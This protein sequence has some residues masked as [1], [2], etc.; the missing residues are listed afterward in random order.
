[1]KS[2]KPHQN[3]LLRR[4]QIGDKFI[5]KGNVRLE[6]CVVDIKEIGHIDHY[7]F[8]VKS[9][10]DELG[11]YWLSQAATEIYFEPKSE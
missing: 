2:N 8:D 7:L 9:T 3:N 11:K 10:S 5:T 6:Y 1:M 4:I